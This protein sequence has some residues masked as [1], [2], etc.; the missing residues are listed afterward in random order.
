MFTAR[1]G[2]IPYIK[3]ITFCLEKVNSKLYSE[4]MNETKPFKR[5]RPRLEGNI[6]MYCRIDGF[7]DGAW[8][9]LMRDPYQR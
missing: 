7:E 4:S 3:K 9:I 5:S 6:K 1:Y 8:I 2:L